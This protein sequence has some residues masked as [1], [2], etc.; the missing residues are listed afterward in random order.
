[1]VFTG[2]LVDF[3]DALS[4]KEKRSDYGKKMWIFLNELKKM[5]E[6]NDLSPQKRIAFQKLFMLQAE[7]LHVLNFLN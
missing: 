4:E 1:M 6:I 3:Y 2:Y 7:N 5:M